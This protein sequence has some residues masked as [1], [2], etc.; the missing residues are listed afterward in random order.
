MH[1]PGVCVGNVIDV[2]APGGPLGGGRRLEQDV[3]TRQQTVQRI[4]AIC[5]LKVEHDTA[6]AT[7]PRP[8]VKG[9][10]VGVA[11][12]PVSRCTPGR[13]FDLDHLGTEISEYAARRLT[14]II[15]QVDDAKV[16][17]QGAHQRCASTSRPGPSSR[18]SH[19]DRPQAARM[20]AAAGPRTSGPVP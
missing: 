2:D 7:A 14:E 6:L 11:R 13:W 17:E 18:S 15:G 5:G 1:Q 10:A 12:T 8:P 9:R 19:T 4:D 3:G 20:I 16:G